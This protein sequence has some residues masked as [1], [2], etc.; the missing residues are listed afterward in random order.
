M[1]IPFL[2]IQY[3]SHTNDKNG[4]NGLDKSKDRQRE[5]CYDKTS[6]NRTC[7]HDMGVL[8]HAI[9]ICFAHNSSYFWH[10]NQ[11]SHK[12]Y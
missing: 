11:I 6:A 12:H 4:Q 10:I 1:H 2:R 5:S 7:D 3:S 8:Y 9:I